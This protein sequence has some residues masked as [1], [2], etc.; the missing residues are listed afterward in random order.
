MAPTAASDHSSV[1]VVCHQACREGGKGGKFS[2]ALRRY[3]VALPSLKNTENCVPDGFFLTS[4]MHKIHFR[5]GLC[6]GPLG[7][8][9]TL[10]QIPS[11][12]V[13][14]GTPLPTFRP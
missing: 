6:P 14:E 9:T 2:R 8:L 5:P 11:R 1:T 12:M 7:Q 4:N 13:T 10:P 3:W